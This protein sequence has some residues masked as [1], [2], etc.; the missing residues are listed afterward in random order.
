VPDFYVVE[1]KIDVSC[2]AD[3][4]VYEIVTEG[5]PP[6]TAT[7]GPYSSTGSAPFPNPSLEIGTFN[8]TLPAG[9]EIVS[10]TISGTWGGNL[11]NSSAPARLFVDLAAIVIQVAQCIE[12]EPC[13]FESTGP[14]SW[15][16]QFDPSEFIFLEEVGV[17]AFTQIQ[18]DVITVDL[19]PTTLTIDTAPVAGE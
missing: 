5:T 3:G 2:H 14:V 18:D 8:Y 13:W 10:A 7:I 19:G 1:D 17:A 15:T 16:Y 4:F 6:V 12:E 11:F 9:E